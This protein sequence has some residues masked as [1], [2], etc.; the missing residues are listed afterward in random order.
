[1]KILLLNDNP[2]VNKLVTLSAQK[3]SDELDVVDSIDG[4]QSGSYDLLVVDD[5]MYNDNMFEDIKSKITFSSSLY[6]CS[7]DAVKVAAFTS[8]LKKPFLPTDLVELFLK[9]AK[10]AASSPS[11]SE[12]DDINLNEPEEELALDEEL[13]LEDDDLDIA[14][15]EELSLNDDLGELDDLEDLEEE[16]SLNDDLGDLDDLADLDEELSFDNDSLEDGES[17]L[18]NEEAQKVKDLL[19]E[20]SDDAIA[21]YDPQLAANELGLPLEEIEEFLQDFIA[22]AEEFKDELY[23]SL[24]TSDLDTIKTLSHKLKGVAANLRIES[25]INPLDIANSSSDTEE[26]ETHLNDFY[27]VIDKLSGV[28]T[29]D[30]NEESMLSEIDE[31]EEFSSEEESES[32]VDELE[33]ELELDEELG[34]EDELDELDLDESDD[35]LD[36]LED[37]LT[38]D[39]DDTLLSELD[40]DIASL[41]EAPKEEELSFENE[42]ELGDTDDLLDELED[43]LILDE[44]DLL[45]ELDE[46]IVAP[47]IEETPKEEES[48]FEDEL[49]L[50]ESDDLEE[51]LEEL[52]EDE[53]TLDDDLLGDLEEEL[54]DE[55]E[56]T[57]SETEETLELDQ[58]DEL[59]SVEEMSEDETIADLDELDEE[60]VLNEEETTSVEELEDLESQI[61]SAVG[62]LSDED[63][64]SELD[65]ETLLEIA[66]NE[67]D[68]FDSLTT[69]DLKLALN[70]EVETIDSGLEEE[71]VE[72]PELLEEISEELEVKVG[73]VEALEKLLEALKD[74]DVAASM[75]GMKININITI[76]EE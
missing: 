5:T 54:S 15:D 72:E 55:E 20:T 61:E 24:K 3:T 43:D 62:E 18:D 63:L 16:F 36:E 32:L 46:E 60:L 76:G 64:E 70:E 47:S 33:D 25:A 74:R 22:Q 65:E 28:D 48:S 58:E 56:S 29:V 34:L 11:I 73:G 42:L 1:M 57:K 67:I 17:V 50:D 45:S 39:E 9:F 59:E 71:V 75:K 21:D 38:V 68:S 31:L 14:L 12:D 27:K 37:D 23:N 8:T 51:K 10:D 66:S 35:L 2:V 7:R 6:I 44:D 30:T 53:L 52:E 40:E 13:S 49:E 4:I 26:I 69:S 41:E 19:E